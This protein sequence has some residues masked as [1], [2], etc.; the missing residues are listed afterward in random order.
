MTARFVFEK[1][2]ILILFMHCFTRTN[3][4]QSAMTF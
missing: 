4:N 2:T 1:F 3:R